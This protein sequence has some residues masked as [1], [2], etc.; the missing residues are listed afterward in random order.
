MFGCLLGS[1]HSGHGSHCPEHVYSGPKIMYL[2]SKQ[3]LKST[4]LELSVAS[5]QC[6]PSSTPSGSSKCSL[7]PPAREQ[8]E[9]SL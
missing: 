2:F 1:V 8:T 7:R 6:F 9:L 3:L 5:S 4:P